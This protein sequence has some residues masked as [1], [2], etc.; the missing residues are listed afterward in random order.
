M[1]S[2]HVSVSKLTSRMPTSC[3]FISKIYMHCV[4]YGVRK[5]QYDSHMIS[6]LH[7]DSKKQASTKSL[8]SC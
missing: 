8:L 1:I 4:L 6:N 5:L 3:Q 2:D 7:E